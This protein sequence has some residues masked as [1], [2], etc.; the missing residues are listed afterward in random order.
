MKSPILTPTL[1]SNEAMEH[2]FYSMVLTL[3]ALQLSSGQISNN[4]LSMKFLAYE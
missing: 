4:T 2:I 3:D 1:S